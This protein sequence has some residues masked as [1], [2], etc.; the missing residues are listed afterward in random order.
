M[1]FNKHC[2]KWKEDYQRF[3]MKS[4]RTF[5]MESHLHKGKHAYAMKT[6]NWVEDETECQ[7]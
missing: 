5:S 2:G 4:E 7:A 1:E 3:K 6:L